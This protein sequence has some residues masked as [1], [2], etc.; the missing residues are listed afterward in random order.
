M[1]LLNDLFWP[2]DQIQRLYDSSPDTKKYLNSIKSDDDVPHNFKII[3]NSV[4]N[5]V[6]YGRIDVPLAGFSKSEIDLGVRPSITAGFSLLVITAKRSKDRV[7]DIDSNIKKLVSNVKN[8]HV[9]LISSDFKIDDEIELTI[10]ID[11][12]LN[13]ENAFAEYKNGVLSILIPPAIN[14]KSNKKS[15]QINGLD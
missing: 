1:D 6:V 12:S 7:S 15:I 13:A 14:K 5:S 4:D 8:T 9:K 10:P 11:G 3:Y 2:N